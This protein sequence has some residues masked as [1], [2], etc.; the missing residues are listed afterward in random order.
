MSEGHAI[1]KKSALPWR[2][3]ASREERI[4]LEHELKQEL[5]EDHSL[6]ACKATAIARRDDDDDV[7]FEVTGNEHRFAVV[8][9]TW[10]GSKESSPMFPYT[11]W[12]DTVK[13]WL[14]EMNAN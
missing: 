11:L 2:L 14:T 1:S 5:K 4:A 13:D 10:S 8:H 6:H 7:L 3:I 9:L 12:Y